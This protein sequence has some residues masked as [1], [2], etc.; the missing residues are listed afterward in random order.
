MLT[1]HTIIKKI[2]SFYNNFFFPSKDLFLWNSEKEEWIVHQSLS[3]C[4]TT[5]R[6]LVSYYNTNQ[7]I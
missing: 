2:S 1:I 5:C 3:I 6:C 7:T 4:K